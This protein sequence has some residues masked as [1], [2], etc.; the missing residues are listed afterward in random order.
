MQYLYLWDIVMERE[1]IIPLNEVSHVECNEKVKQMLCLH[2]KD[3]VNFTIYDDNDDYIVIENMDGICFPTT[4][5]KIKI[6]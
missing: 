3:N 5:E 2:L 4:K 1:I 6:C